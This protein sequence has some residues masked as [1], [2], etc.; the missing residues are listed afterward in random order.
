MRVYEEGRSVANQAAVLYA[1]RTRAPESRV[2]FAVGKKL[3]SAVV[4]NRAK[5]RLREAVRLLW[6]VI[7]GGGAFVVIARRPALDMPFSELLRKTAE[8]FRRAGFLKEKD[9]RVRALLGAKGQ[10]GRGRTEAQRP[11]G[12]EAKA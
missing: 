1:V 8:L 6:P 4:R 5:R 7:K 10:S 3:G 11:A 9:P 12:G 2:G